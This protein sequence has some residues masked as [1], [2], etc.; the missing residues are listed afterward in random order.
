[1]V[2]ADEYLKQ[3]SRYIHLNPMR[4]K[5]VDHLKDYRW[6]SYPAFGGY[7]KAPPWLETG[8]L[9]SLFGKDKERYRQFVEKVHNDDLED[10]SKDVVG[11][12]ILCSTEFVDWIKN[13]F[14]DKQADNKEQPQ[15][16]SLKPRISAENLIPFICAEFSCEPE[17][18]IRKGSKN[19]CARDVAIYLSR[20][21]TS[22]SGV[23]LGQFFG[24]I[25][26]AGV[27][28]RYN[29]I[30]KRLLT[31]RKLKRQLSKIKSRI[32]NN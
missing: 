24:G 7:E 11:G 27:T 6:S 8:W 14:L 5:M 30:K 9:L 18:I 15:L 21:M 12:L 1:V 3:L 2:D 28:V 22:D 20:E 26:G 4:A 19:N 16:K 29:H 23:E 10:P 13:A 25:S 17:S 32:V 31:D